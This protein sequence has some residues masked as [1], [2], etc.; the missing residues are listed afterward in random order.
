MPDPL[1]GQGYSLRVSGGFC[2][3]PDHVNNNNNN[4]NNTEKT[5]ETAGGRS[6]GQKAA[7]PTQKTTNSQNPFHAAQPRLTCDKLHS[8]SDRLNVT[9]SSEALHWLGW[10]EHLNLTGLNQ[11][12][13]NN[14]Y[15]AG[16]ARVSICIENKKFFKKKFSKRKIQK[17]SHFVP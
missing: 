11:P 6:A 12:H 16:S 2:H 14:L 9:T 5:L 3:E 13:N 10:S 15:T 7:L 4:N 1:P 17:I 8:P